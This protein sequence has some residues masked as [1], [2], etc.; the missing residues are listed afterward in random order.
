MA[1]AF[2]SAIRSETQI[3]LAPEENRKRQS[4][5]DAQLAAKKQ[6]ASE[7]ETTKLPTKFREWLATAPAAEQLGPWETLHIVALNASSGTK[8]EQQT[9]ASVLATGTTPAKEAITVVAESFRPGVRALRVE[10]LAHD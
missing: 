8:L 10:A 2:G 6:A 1:A 4:D 3:D 7:F 5:F 9:D